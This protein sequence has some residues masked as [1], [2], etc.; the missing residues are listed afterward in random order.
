MGGGV[1][2]TANGKGYLVLEVERIT[3]YSVYGR[4][5]SGQEGVV[6]FSYVTGDF[7]FYD[8]TNPMELNCD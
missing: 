4:L 1:S 7:G 8:W 5:A 3:N 2:P 6:T